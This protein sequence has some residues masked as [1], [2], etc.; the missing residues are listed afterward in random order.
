L[1]LE[2]VGEPIVER[3]VHEDRRDGG[4]GDADTGESGSQSNGERLRI[5][6]DLS[7]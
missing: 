3:E 1:V 4:G 5:G 6:L 2:V 7:L